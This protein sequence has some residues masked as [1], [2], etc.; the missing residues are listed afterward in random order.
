VCSYMSLR[1]S[2]LVGKKISKYPCL[3]RSVVQ[4]TVMFR[5]RVWTTGELIPGIVS[6]KDEKSDKRRRCRGKLF[7]RVRNRLNSRVG[8]NSGADRLGA[9]GRLT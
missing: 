7:R 3:T 8:I 2:K 9:N 5:N 1:R 4:G 6:G